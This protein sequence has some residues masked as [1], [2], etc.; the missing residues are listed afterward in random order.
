MKFISDCWFPTFLV[1]RR[2]T[3]QMKP[4]PNHSNE[5]RADLKKTPSHKGHSFHHF[6]YWHLRDRSSIYWLDGMYLHQWLRGILGRLTKNLDFAVRSINWE[7]FEQFTKAMISGDPKL[8]LETFIPYR[9]TYVTT[10]KTVD[11]MPFGALALP[12]QI[13]SWQDGNLMSILGL[14]EAWRSRQAIKSHQ[15]R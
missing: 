11:I 6:H 8:F 15:R 10:G 5:Y 4:K 3:S 7:D 14:D 9:F 2:Q 12:H 13:I 1:G